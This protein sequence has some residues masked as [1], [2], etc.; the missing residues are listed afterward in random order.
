[1]IQHATRDSTIV[2]V[3]DHLNTDTPV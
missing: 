2:R 3:S 1:V